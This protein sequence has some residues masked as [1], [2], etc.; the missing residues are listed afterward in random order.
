MLF[1]SD[2]LDHHLI[3]R[4]QAIVLASL[5][6]AGVQFWGARAGIYLEDLAGDNHRVQ[7]HIESYLHIIESLEETNAQLLNAKINSS[8]QTFTILAF[9]TFPLVLFTSIYALNHVGNDFW[10][11]FIAIAIITLVLPFILRQRNIF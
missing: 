6:R 9:F 7:Q 4:P 11:G 3:S 10:I 2:L 5:S 8:V 1:R